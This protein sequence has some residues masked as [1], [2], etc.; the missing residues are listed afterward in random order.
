MLVIAIRVPPAVKCINNLSKVFQ[1]K[2]KKFHNKQCR[3]WEDTG[4]HLARTG[5]VKVK[6]SI[7]RPGQT[8]WA[9]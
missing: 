8:L 1:L 3:Y 9:S 5:K 4:E 6:L 2:K 7:Y